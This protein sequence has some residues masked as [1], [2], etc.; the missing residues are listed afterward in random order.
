MKMY[1][2]NNVKITDWLILKSSKKSKT[3]KKDINEEM[4]MNQ[5]MMNQEMM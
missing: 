2:D 1:K 5:E 4:I 3:D